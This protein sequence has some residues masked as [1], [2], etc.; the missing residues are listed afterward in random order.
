M[1]V[2][3]GYAGCQAWPSALSVA[4][5]IHFGG[6]PTDFTADASG[7]AL[8]PSVN[9]ADW[10]NLISVQKYGPQLPKSFECNTEL[11]LRC[12]IFNH[13]FLIQPNTSEIEAPEEIL[14]MDDLLEF[15]V[16][17]DISNDVII[18]LP[19]EDWFL[20]YSRECC[21]NIS[22]VTALETGY[23]PLPPWLSF[24][25]NLTQSASG[26]L[27]TANHS[28]KV[29]AQPGL[30]AVGNYTI[31]I[32]ATDQTLPALPAHVDVQLYIIGEG[33]TV[34]SSF[35]LLEVADGQPLLFSL[36]GDVIQLNKPYGQLSYTAEQQGGL[37]LPAWLSFGESGTLSGTP[38]EGNDRTLNLTV[39]ATD[40]DGAH[41]STF[42]LLYVK[43]P[44]PAGLFR[45]FRL[46]ISAPTMQAGTIR[47]DTAAADL[48]FAQLPGRRPDHPRQASHLLQ[49]Q[50]SITS[51]GPRITHRSIM[52]ALP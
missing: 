39:T 26:P 23:Q 8:Q 7:Q 49:R 25:Y 2:D 14:S 18:P 11:Y 30:A 46:Q 37:P 51:A 15:E 36:P 17:V 50:H 12:G 52:M 4:S 28:L 21:L 42:L 31:R 6:M 1:A 47:S 40:A 43:A 35:P 27:L 9:S 38:T 29:S 45:H 44:C 33:P 32:I 19:I 20:Q 13:T 5:P 10:T 3:L 22:A 16:S 34:V 41:N 48:P 24:W